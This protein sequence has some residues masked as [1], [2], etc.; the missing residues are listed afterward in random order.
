MPTREEA[1]EVVHRSLNLTPPD[2]APGLSDGSDTPTLEKVESDANQRERV[3]LSCFPFSI[4]GTEQNSIRG[5]ILLL[6]V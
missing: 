2:E 1:P 6:L 4:L 3:Q 5:S